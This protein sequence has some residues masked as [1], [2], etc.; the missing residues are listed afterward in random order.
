M[1]D[2]PSPPGIVDQTKLNNEPLLWL[3]NDVSTHTPHKM[4]PNPPPPKSAARQSKV[5]LVS[6]DDALFRYFKIDS[7][8]SS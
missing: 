3:Q 2:I 8:R 1:V 5:R 4:T 6:H 7:V